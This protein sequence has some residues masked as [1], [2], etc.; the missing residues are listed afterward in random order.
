MDYRQALRDY[1]ERLKSTRD[2]EGVILSEQFTHK[3]DELYSRIN[4]TDHATGTITSKFVYTRI[5]LH[6]M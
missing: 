6:T 3:L 4:T 1:I 2:T 5:S